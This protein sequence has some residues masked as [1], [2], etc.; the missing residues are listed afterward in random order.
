MKSISK[1]SKKLLL[2][3][4]IAAVLVLLVLLSAFGYS[5]YVLTS[6]G[7]MAALC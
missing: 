1:S 4:L 3:F 5:L 6:L 2:A 7:V